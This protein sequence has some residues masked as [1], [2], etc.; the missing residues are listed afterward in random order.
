MIR[1]LNRFYCTDVV[2]YNQDE[3]YEILNGYV[4]LE[5]EYD[6][7]YLISGDSKIIK[8]NNKHRLIAKSDSSIICRNNL[9][10]RFFGH[11]HRYNFII[12]VLSQFVSIKNKNVVDCACGKGIGSNI[13]R[14]HG[15]L[16]K[17]VDIDSNIIN[18]AS[19][20]FPEITFVN[21]NICILSSVPKDSVD[22]F[23]CSETLE[24]LDANESLDAVKS[25]L[26]VVTNGGY[27]CVTV[28]NDESICLS[29][30]NV[31]NNGHKQY[32]S[33]D[34]LINLFSHCTML[35]CGLFYKSKKADGANLVLIF[36]KI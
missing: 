27:I 34:N 17:G 14:G 26:R 4:I 8:K 2:A 10:L 5:D 1:Q 15:A 32:L 23:V 21:D 11:Y 35:Y 33:L 31:Y 3:C 29:Q 9:H 18:L 24:H 16:V 30:R 22:I 28:P 36:Q 25:I 12:K 6:V 19:N 13:I 7:Y 20:N